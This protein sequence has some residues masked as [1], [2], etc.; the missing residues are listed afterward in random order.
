MV[1][2]NVIL[3]NLDYTNIYN[4]YR[5]HFQYYEY[6]MKYNEKCSVYYVIQLIVDSNE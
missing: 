4:I 6:L 3:H 2:T 5:K 1:H